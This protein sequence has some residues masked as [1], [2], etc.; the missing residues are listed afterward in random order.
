MTDFEEAVRTAARPCR[1][2]L[3]LLSSAAHTLRQ[4]RRFYHTSEALRP[5][6]HIYRCSRIPTLRTTFSSFGGR[7]ERAEELDARF[8]NQTVGLF[9]SFRPNQAQ[10]ELLGC[11][12]D[13]VSG[14]LL[15]GTSPF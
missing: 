9:S 12:I 8:R 5:H 7:A 13:F 10:R 14:R 6:P 1:A 15:M 3:L 11:R 4:H 2:P